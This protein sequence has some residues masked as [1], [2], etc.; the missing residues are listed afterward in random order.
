VN[1]RRKRRTLVVL[2]FLFMFTASSPWTEIRRTCQRREEVSVSRTTGMYD[3]YCSSS[4]SSSSLWHIRIANDGSLGLHQSTLCHAGAPRRALARGHAV[5]VVR[6]RRLGLYPSGR[7]E[8]KDAATVLT[9]GPG[10]APPCPHRGR[11]YRAR[12]HDGARQSVCRAKRNAPTRA[13][14]GNV[15]RAAGAAAA[16]HARVGRLSH[17]E[18]RSEAARPHCQGAAPRAAEPGPPRGRASRPR[19]VAGRSRPSRRGQGSPRHGV[20]RPGRR[21]WC[22]TVAP[23]SCRG[24]G[25]ARADGVVSRLTAPPRGRVSASA[26]GRSLLNRGRA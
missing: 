9:S 14:G 13:V 7:T 24:E 25:R 15:P 11:G 3:V 5:G 19:R 10:P 8:A 16:H 12:A 17:H 1:A 2:D 4:Y 20:L 22:P 21:C 18:P 23:A 26:P 6:L